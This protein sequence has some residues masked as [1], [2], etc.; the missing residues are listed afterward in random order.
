VTKQSS[1]WLAAGFVQISAFAVCLGAWFLSGR[2]GE[3]RDLWNVNPHYMLL[4]GVMGAFITYTV[5]QA[6]NRC[7]PARAVVFIVVSQIIVA[8]VIELLGAFG[9]E[10]QP[11]E[12]RKA[13]GIVVLMIGIYIFKWK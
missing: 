6:M 9:V 2:E 13:I 5:I 4:G 3:V 12:W 7:G 11:F 8:Y 1:I 10:K